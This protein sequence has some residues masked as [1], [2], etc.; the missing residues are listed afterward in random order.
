MY[1]RK[2]VG[3]RIKPQGTPALTAYSCENFPFR[4]TQSCLRKT[5]KGQVSDLK[6]HEASVTTFRGTAVD[7]KDLK[8]YWKSE[9]WPHF[10][11]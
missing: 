9:K 5:K 10:S 3:P 1:G 7:L 4:T 2:G 11:S 8:P 6:F